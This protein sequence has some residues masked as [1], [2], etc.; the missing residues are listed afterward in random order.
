MM[1]LLHYHHM[2]L[3]GPL[4]ILKGTT[5]SSNIQNLFNE[6]RFSENPFSMLYSTSKYALEVFE[7]YFS[8]KS[9]GK[10]TILQIIIS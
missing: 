10:S 4:H 8:P 5:Y 7:K 1:C 6:N 9:L 3:K 2:Y